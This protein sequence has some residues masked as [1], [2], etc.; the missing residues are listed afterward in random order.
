[1]LTECAS[2]R[3]V[4]EWCRFT[5]N[6]RFKAMKKSESS[7]RCESGVKSKQKKVAFGDPIELT[8]EGEV[9]IHHGKCGNTGCVYNCK[10]KQAEGFVELI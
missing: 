5:G 9:V 4:I 2:M 3:T 7:V 6:L 8:W 1:M 10:G